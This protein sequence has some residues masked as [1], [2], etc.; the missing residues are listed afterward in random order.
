MINFSRTGSCSLLFVLRMIGS[1]H[2]FTSC[3][4][5]STVRSGNFC[6]DRP[7]EHECYGKSGSRQK[8]FCSSPELDK[9]FAVRIRK[10]GEPAPSTHRSGL[11][12][13]FILFERRKWTSYTKNLQLPIRKF[14][15]MHYLPLFR[16]KILVEPTKADHE[17]SGQACMVLHDRPSGLRWLEHGS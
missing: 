2:V 4:R 16:M 13:L 3:L 9:R 5:K 12:Y 17:G 7:T 14:V 15:R 6:H 8:P 10:V 11:L 1:R